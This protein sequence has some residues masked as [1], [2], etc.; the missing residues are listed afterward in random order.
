MAENAL[1]EES[2]SQAAIEDIQVAPIEETAPPDEALNVDAEPDEIKTTEIEEDGAAENSESNELPIQEFERVLKA[3]N[4][5][6][7]KHQLSLEEFYKKAKE[8]KLLKI[9]QSDLEDPDIAELVKNK[10]IGAEKEN[11]ENKFKK[12]GEFILA[13]LAA[14]GEAATQDTIENGVLRFIRALVEGANYNKGSSMRNFESNAENEGK[15][16]SSSDFFFLMR[17]KPQDAIEKLLESSS[18]LEK[19]GW[20]I[21]KKG[22]ELLQ[23]AQKDPSLEKEALMAVMIGKG[24]DGVTSFAEHLS[25][26]DDNV[27]F[28]E[29]GS[30]LAKELFGQEM[31]ATS[32]KDDLED[33]RSGKH[34]PKSRSFFG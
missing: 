6:L 2:S 19:T 9:I 11:G 27:R 16:T 15:V 21:G 17:E 5:D 28:E 32:I 14:W 34:N 4:V 1:K 25:A 22:L 7:E 8:L 3:L 20:S 29:T 10:L 26:I 31:L 13:H 12:T 23:K 30:V 24:Q 33:L 18:K